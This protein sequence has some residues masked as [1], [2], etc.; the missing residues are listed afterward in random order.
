MNRT[1]FDHKCFVSGWKLQTVIAW[2]V[3]VLGEPERPAQSRAPHSRR[4]NPWEA[5]WWHFS[6]HCTSAATTWCLLDPKDGDETGIGTPLGASGEQNWIPDSRL[7]HV[8]CYASCLS[9]S[10]NKGQLSSRPTK[11]A[12]LPTPTVESGFHGSTFLLLHY[13]KRVLVVHAA[14][15]RQSWS[16]A[17]HNSFFSSSQKSSPKND[18]LGER[19][20][21]WPGTRLVWPVWTRASCTCRNC[22][23]ALEKRVGGNATASLC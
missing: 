15:S 11:T 14:G 23:S 1:K 6:R 2:Q 20:T 17:F 4:V 7:L 21:L 9:W 12:T 18:A 10:A 13:S 22:G 19:R 5:S 16:V 3:L 8:P